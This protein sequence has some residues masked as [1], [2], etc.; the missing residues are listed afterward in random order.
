MMAEMVAETISPPPSLGQPPQTGGAAENSAKGAN[1]AAN[2]QVTNQQEA[3]V[4]PRV[5]PAC[6]GRPAQEWHTAQRRGQQETNHQET[7]QQEAEAASAPGEK[8]DGSETPA[9]EQEQQPRRRQ[10]SGCQPETGQKAE[11]CRRTCRIRTTKTLPCEARDCLPHD[12]STTMC[13]AAPR[14]QLDDVY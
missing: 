11:Y 5:E 10:L 3:E 2:Q 6:P 8:R 4:E 12:V 9:P 14:C 7:N 1:G 13:I